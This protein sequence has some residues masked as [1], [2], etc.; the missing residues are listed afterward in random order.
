MRNKV[1]LKQSVLA[2]EKSMVSM[3]TLYM[4]LKNRG[5]P[6]KSTIARVLVFLER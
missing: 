2:V 1:V 4:I 3:A 6:T 5:R